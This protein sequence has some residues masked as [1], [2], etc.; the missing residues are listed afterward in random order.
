MLMKVF[1]KSFVLFLLTLMIVTAAVVS[2]AE[3]VGRAD[4]LFSGEKEYKAIRLVPEIY[5]HSN[6]DLSDLL[7]KDDYGNVLPYFINSYESM[8]SQAFIETTSLVVTYRFVK[9]GNS[10]VDFRVDVPNEHRDT[11]ATSFIVQTNSSLFAKNVNVWG[12]HD[13]VEWVL[14]QND[15]L[16]RVDGTEK[17]DIVFREIQRFTHYRIR[18]PNDGNNDL[19]I[20][21]AL[22]E[23][24]R[25]TV[26]KNFFTE[27]FTPA[28][29]VTHEERHTIIEIH[30]LRNVS[31]SEVTIHT[32]SRFRRSVSFAERQMRELYNLYFASG[33]Q[34]QN[35]TLN[36]DGYIER[37][38][39]TIVMIYNGD[40]SPI[41]IESITLTYLAD[42]LVFRI[43]A[44]SGGTL[45]FGNPAIH[46]PPAYDIANYKALIL[47]QGYDLLSLRNITI[48]E[49]EE[50]PVPRDFTM[51]FNIVV[52]TIAILLAFVILR[53]LR[54][55][56]RDG[57]EE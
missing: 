15:S 26:E 13:G 12:S 41:D 8:V 7:L 54:V 16:Y 43:G 10:Y 52:V 35:L 44:G 22:L 38:D 30:G 34:Y 32:D 46:L 17:L 9:Y 53:Q 45:T 49:M 20:A 57:Q 18:I 42:E 36:F 48:G 47:A 25:Y 5:N 6:R 37:G 55:R 23:Y 4:F 27:S 11:L 1:R 19:V 14:I 39:A 24:N 29:D 3:S 31:I 33:E 51:I 21:G 2:A 56:R 50:A 40:D 28:F